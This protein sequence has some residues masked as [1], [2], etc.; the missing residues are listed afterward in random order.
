MVLRFFVA[1]AILIVL[2]WAIR[3]INATATEWSVGIA[4]P[5]LGTPSSIRI[6]FAFSLF[7]SLLIVLA[8]VVNRLWGI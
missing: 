2:D 4:I 5:F 7:L 3:F 8:Y 6:M 1:F